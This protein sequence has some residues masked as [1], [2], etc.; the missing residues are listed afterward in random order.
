MCNRR[1]PA[2]FRLQSMLISDVHW[3][4]EC[5]SSK[6]SADLMR[7]SCVNAQESLYHFGR[8]VWKTEKKAVSDEAIVCH[9]HYCG[10]ALLRLIQIEREL[11]AADVQEVLPNFNE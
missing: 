3:L 9:S 11:P 8:H 2:T 1:V 10:P 5:L 6:L 7:S 4:L